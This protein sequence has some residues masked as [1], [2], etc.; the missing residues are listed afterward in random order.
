MPS[1]EVWGPGVWNLLHTLAATIDENAFNVIF[2]QLFVFIKRICVFL[3]CPDCAKHATQFLSRLTPQQHLF[4]KEK[5]INTFYLFHNIVNTKK[6]KS[7]YNYANMEKYKYIPISFAFNNFA[8]VYNTKGN[9]KL[10]TDSFQRQII[11]KEFKIWLIK[12][13]RFF[14]HKT[15][16]TQPQ[17]QIQTQTQIIEEKYEDQT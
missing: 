2:P 11:V 7:L 3:P 12:N 9:M 8:K 6:N 4:T 14:K 1:I 17:I 10:L 13:I 5:F 15:K 16:Q